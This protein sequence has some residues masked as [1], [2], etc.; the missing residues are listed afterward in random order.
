MESTTGAFTTV[1]TGRANAAML[2][3]IVVGT[4]LPVLCMLSLAHISLSWYE[5]SVHA[6]QLGLVSVHSSMEQPAHIVTRANLDYYRWT[7][8]ERPRH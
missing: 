8:M 6:Q 2:D 1:R 4:H 7:T 5:C 3:R